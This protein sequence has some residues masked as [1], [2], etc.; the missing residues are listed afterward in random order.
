MVGS[1]VELIPDAVCPVLRW[2]ARLAFNNQVV[3][4]VNVQQWGIQVQRVVGAPD[5]GPNFVA[6]D[7]LSPTRVRCANGFPVPAFT[8]PVP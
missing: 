6:Y 7:G 5:A 4:Q 8:L 2:S 1:P 3:T